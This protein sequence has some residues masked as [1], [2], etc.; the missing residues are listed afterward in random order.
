V[1]ARTIAAPFVAGIALSAFLLFAVQPLFGRLVLP[2]F[3]GAPAAWA[4]VLVGFQAALLIGYAYAHLSVGRLGP[5]RGALVHLVLLVVGLVVLA[6]APARFVDVRVESLPPAIDLLRLFALTI[7]LPAAALAATTPLMSAWFS[8]LRGISPSLDP[9]RFYAVSNAGS[10][11]AVVAYPFVVE[12]LIGLAA[13]RIAFGLGLATL[14]G[15][16]AWAAIVVRRSA[17]EPRIGPSGDAAVDRPREPAA[18]TIRPIRLA[19]WLLLAAV[20]TGLLAAVTNFVATD[21]ISAPLLWIGPLAIYLV[22]L[23]IAFGGRGPAIAA[24]LAP[25]GAITIAVLAVPDAAPVDWP[26]A[27][28]L[29]VEYGGLGILALI[30]HGGLAGDRPPADRLTSY[31]LVIAVGGV[32][33]GA[34]VALLAPALFDGVWE[35]PILLVAAAGA[36]AA[37][38]ALADAATA[39][40][41][42]RRP[43]PRLLDL[44]PL[45]SGAGRRL[46]IYLAIAG[47]LG[48]LLTLSRSVAVSDASTWL[49]IGAVLVTFGG[50]PRAFTAIAA[51]VLTLAILS[52]PPVLFRDRSFFGVVEVVAPEPPEFT[53][54]RHGTTVHS[55]QATDPDRRRE[56][57]GYFSREGPLGEVIARLDAR[58]D[59]APRRLVVTGLGAGTIAAYARPSDTISFLELDETMARVAGDPT[60]FTYLPDAAVEPRIIIGDGR[61]ELERFAGASAELVVLDAFASDAVPVH[62]LTVEALTDAGRVLT[63][64]GLLAINVS[65]RYYDLGPAGAAGVAPLGMVTLRRLHEPSEA[66]ADRG[67]TTSDWLVA[68]DDATDVDWFEAAGWRVVPADQ[69]PLTDDHADIL[70][71]LR[72]DALF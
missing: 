15:L 27:P 41:H 2:A 62:L 11:V 64:D 65:S 45:V 6:A 35:Y 42:R 43:K 28:L 29:A 44:A 26:V 55:L 34:F 52:P 60:L 1:P 24:R 17:P 61:L 4:T 32:L 20:P 38:P 58:R 56:P 39:P 13:Q 68:T 16:F 37:T 30:L 3:G 14:L 47:A 53:V 36:I 72:T 9:Y 69:P 31:Y 7:G 63:P 57:I 10:L 50:E 59:E 67:I 25:L 18:S 54:L 66:E 8:A 33:G 5:R 48:V 71:L 49:L 12:P 40:L 22:S 19:R 51:G 70:R 23:V 46:V 21:L